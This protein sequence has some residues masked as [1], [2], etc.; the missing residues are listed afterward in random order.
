MKIVVL[1]DDLPPYHVGGG[2]VVAFRLAREFARMGHE[3]T[4]ITTVQDRAHA[5]SEILAG[6][7]VHRLYSAYH[8]RWR[9]YRS[10]YNKAVAHDVKRLLRELA[11]DIVHAHNVHT[12]LSYYSLVLAKR[13]ARNVVMTEHD[14]MSFHFGKLPSVTDAAAVE[15]PRETYRESFVRQLQ[16]H[17]WRYNPL[18]TRIIKRV[19]HIT[20]DATVAVSHALGRALEMNGIRV[21]TV[22]HNGIDVAQWENPTTVNEFKRRLGLGEQVIFFGGRLSEPKG[23]IQILEALS[24][25]RKTCPNAQLL[26]AGKQDAF[27]ERMKKHAAR[28]GIETGLVFAGWLDGEDLKN[29]YHASRVVVVPSIYLD[30]FPTVNL[31]AYAA[32]KPVVATCFGGSREI[33]E[34]GVSGFVVNPLN[35]ETFSARVADLLT[36]EEKGKRFGAAGHERVT[37]DFT[38]EGQARAYEKV[39]AE[40]Y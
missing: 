15:L 24:I 1:Q 34:D 12:H 26:I 8:P 3:V 5:G 30:P 20:V 17:A 40:L 36:D 31:E 28:C 23:A 29:A 14:A 11:P 32:G 10:L 9:A 33:V 16:M 6:I 21:R 19:L 7:K 18:R 35:V 38:L 13:F 2:G 37:R 27:A 39:F 22:I 4:A 25:I